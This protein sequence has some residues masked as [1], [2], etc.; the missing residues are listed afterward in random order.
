MAYKLKITHFAVGQGLCVA[1]TLRKD[2]ILNFLGILDMGSDSGVIFAAKEVELIKALV[3]ERKRKIDYVLVSHQDTD[4]YN[5]F[6]TLGA[7]Y[8][9]KIEIGKLLLGFHPHNECQASPAEAIFSK[10]YTFGSCYRI[11]RQMLQRTSK[12][13]YDTHP[14]SEIGLDID[15]NMPLH[16]N[17]MFQIHCLLGGS[18]ERDSTNEASVI[19]LVSIYNA[20]TKTPKYSYL[21][22]GDATSFTL[23]KFNAIQ[24]VFPENQ[25]HKAVLIPHHGSYS[26]M[27]SK[28]KDLS[29]LETLLHIY[30]PTSAYVSARNLSL[31]HPSKEILSLFELKVDST[32]F[33]HEITSIGYINGEIYVDKTNKDI[34]CTF[35]LPPRCNRVNVDNNF[36]Q[37]Y[38]GKHISD[39]YIWQ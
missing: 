34:Y 14:W 16:G 32:I 2:N 30:D 10:H 18:T 5:L 28:S 12:D 33:E 31:K 11:S 24:Y 21:F 39:G 20:T 13:P 35:N 6:E 25:G 29:D 1:V 23:E 17:E 3:D 27:L 38:T 26:T 15:I 22:T 4:H 7:K 8:E 37:Y 9:Q 36:V 19:A